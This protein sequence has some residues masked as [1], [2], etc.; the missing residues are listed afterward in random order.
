MEEPAWSTK[1][2]NRAR[3]IARDNEARRFQR[4]KSPPL[5]PVT[6]MPTKT[7]VGDVAAH[8]LPP[9]P[10]A[11]LYVPP[12]TL[13]KVS[14]TAYAFG[15][16]QSGYFFIPAEVLLSKNSLGLSGRTGDDGPALPTV[17]TIDE[18][19]NRLEGLVPAAV[20]EAAAAAVAAA[21]VGGMLGVEGVEGNNFTPTSA[22]KEEPYARYTDILPGYAPAFPV[23]A[24]R[25]SANDQ[26]AVQPRRRVGVLAVRATLARAVLADRRYPTGWCTRP[27]FVTARVARV[28]WRNEIAS[29]KREFSVSDAAYHA[30]RRCHSKAAGLRPERVQINP[31]LDRFV[32]PELR[33]ERDGREFGWTGDACYGRGEHWIETRYPGSGCK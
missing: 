17:V 26:L 7:A 27:P 22:S 14:S 19:R 5:P 21:S 25:N 6:G 33:R 23:P 2:K 11:Q 4:D 9:V 18:S 10:P 28:G 1:T 13:T 8:R 20:L 16:D 31:P 30:D 32:V 29:T 15:N 24:I 3:F 12:M